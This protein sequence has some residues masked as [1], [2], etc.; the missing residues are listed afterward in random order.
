MVLD[1]LLSTSSTFSLY[2][3][4]A[5][6]HN[7]TVKAINTIGILEYTSPKVLRLSLETSLSTMLS[8]L[9]VLI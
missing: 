6:V 1:Y 5:L 3:N 7:N 2:I 9:S 8:K 4:K